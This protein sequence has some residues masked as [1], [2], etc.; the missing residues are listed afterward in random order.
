MSEIT[1]LQLF[2]AFIG[3]KDFVKTCS[4]IDQKLGGIGVGNNYIYNI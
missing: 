1:I 4:K 3:S 2:S